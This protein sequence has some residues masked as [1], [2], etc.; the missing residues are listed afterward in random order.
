MGQ[1]PAAVLAVLLFSSAGSAWAECKWSASASHAEYRACLEREVAQADALV[2]A[3]V[4]SAKRR[5]SDSAEDAEVTQRALE[6][7]RFSLESFKRYRTQH[8]AYESSTAAGGNSAGDL[9]ALCELA[10]TNSYVE[11]LKSVHGIGAR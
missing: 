11:R 1:K 3:A 9:R 5:I 6:A 4:A 7:L 10:L 2:I 8:C